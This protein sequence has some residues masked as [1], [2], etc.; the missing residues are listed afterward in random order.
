MFGGRDLL[1]DDDQNHHSLLL[2]PSFEVGMFPLMLTVLGRDDSTPYGNPYEGL[3]VKGGA[4][5][6]PSPTRQNQKTQNPKPHAKTCAQA[7]PPTQPNR[8]STI[9]EDGKSLGPRVTVGCPPPP[10]PPLPP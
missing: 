9:Q 6:P 10:P 2:K 8:E 5:Q 4:S 1:A 7:L 3:L